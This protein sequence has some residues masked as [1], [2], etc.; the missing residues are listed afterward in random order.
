MENRMIEMKFDG[1]D[2]FE[3]QVYGK[4]QNTPFVGPERCVWDDDHEIPCKEY[5]ICKW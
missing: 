5:A 2:D 4:F 3:H 1:F